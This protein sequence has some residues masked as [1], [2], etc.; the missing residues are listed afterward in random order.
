MNEKYERILQAQQ[1]D[2]NQMTLKMALLV[3][4]IT[5]CLYY[6]GLFDEKRL[7]EGIPSIFGL[8]I[9]SLP[10]DF[11]EV[12]NWVKP[13]LDTLAMSVAGTAIAVFFSLPLGLLSARNTSPHPLVYI[14]S[15]GLLNGLRSIPELIMGIVF[16]AAVGFGSLPGVLALG[17]HSVGMVGKF[18]AEAIEHV[19]EEPVEAVQAAGGRPMQVVLHGVLPQIL[20]QVADVSIYRWEYNFRASTVMGMVGAGGIGFE[21]I[22]SLRLMQY[23]EVS[24]ILIVILV[25]VTLV[26]GFGA[27][28]RRRFE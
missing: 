28:L 20:S 21:L 19:A 7:M 16:V 3:P 10:P 26:D 15:R 8:I 22:G 6:V 12:R 11:T 9:E 14:L 13:L 5:A 1:R 2:W 4:V 27:F 18:F 24:A 23:R 17:L 25:M